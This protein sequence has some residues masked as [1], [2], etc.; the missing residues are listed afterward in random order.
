MCTARGVFFQGMAASKSRLAECCKACALTL[1]LPEPTP[2]PRHPHDGPG[3]SPT[4]PV[5]ASQMLTVSSCDPEATIALSRLSDTLR[6]GP[7]CP[8]IVCTRAP[9]TQGKGSRRYP[10]SSH[11][12]ILQMPKQR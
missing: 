6:T 3:P 10:Q 5:A 8:F 7:L 2:P 11:P 4:R 9:A 1:T 12:N